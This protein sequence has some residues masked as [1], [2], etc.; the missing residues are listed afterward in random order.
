MKKDLLY[1]RNQLLRAGLKKEAAQ[2]N[3]L[4]TEPSTWGNYIADAKR[5]AKSFLFGKEQFEKPTNVKYKRKTADGII[6]LGDKSSD[7]K[8]LQ[9]K[10]IEK[11]YLA[12]GAND[13]ALGP[14][15]AEALFN[16][17]GFDITQAR[18]GF[19]LNDMLTKIDSAERGAN[20]LGSTAKRR[21]ARPKASTKGDSSSTA[22]DVPDSG[23]LPGMSSLLS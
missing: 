20:P 22:K 18:D 11:N 15:T 2:I 4:A 5:K 10:L 6:R 21:V 3:K 14:T 23:Q 17:T 1:L 8:K 12:Q 9:N 19:D 16:A 13:S 7:V